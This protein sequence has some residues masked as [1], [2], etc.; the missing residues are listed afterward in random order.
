MVGIAAVYSVKA[1]VH[2]Q[3]NHIRVFL[4]CVLTLRLE[5]ETVTTN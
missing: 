2:V 5:R 3:I 1:S 4:L